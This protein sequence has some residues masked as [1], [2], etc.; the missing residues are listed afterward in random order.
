MGL[1]KTASLMLVAFI[2]SG[3]S[4]QGASVGDGG[5][6]TQAVASAVPTA[7]EAPTPQSPKDLLEDHRKE[8]TA[9]AEAG[10]YPDVCKGTPWV[11]GAICNWAAARASGKSVGRPDGEIFRAYFG[12]E[13]WKHIYGQIIADADSNG[14][15]EVSVGGYRHHCILDTDD[16]K[17]TTKGA[18]DLWVQEQPETREVTVNSGATEQWVVLEEATLAKMLMDL[19]HSGGGIEATAL[20]KN[21]MGLIA[22]YQT[23]AER[24]GEPP[25]LPSA[26]AAAPVV[27]AV[28]PG[29][30]LIAA[31]PTT[32]P[33]S[34]KP[35]SAPARSPANTISRTPASAPGPSP[36]DAEKRA[37]ARSGC[38]QKCV[39]GCNDDAA[40]ERACAGKCPAG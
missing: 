17:F 28:A 18:F 31:A 8:M 4:K 7:E 23:Y 13:H 25:A 36:D 14:D 10:N 21:A 22:T 12:K 6:A 38:L 27:A 40:C 32:S 35:S 2:V 1:I 33:T 29:T 39:G 34:A 5:P 15:Y 20:A 16:T 24:K 37:K 3:C 26:S 9:A 11:N 30:P 19:A